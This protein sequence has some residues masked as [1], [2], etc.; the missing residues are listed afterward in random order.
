[1]PKETITLDEVL[2]RF[3]EAARPKVRVIFES[4]KFNFLITRPNE[5]K[6]GSFRAGMPGRN[7]VIFINRNLSKYGFLLIFLHEYAHFVVWKRQYKNAAP[8]GIEWKNCYR[9]ILYSFENENLFPDILRPHIRELIRTA[10][11]SFAKNMSL[12]DALLKLEGKAAPQRLSSLSAGA[13]FQLNGRQFVVVDKL[14]TRY[15]CR[16]ADDGR[17]YLISGNASIVQP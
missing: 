17:L 9:E 1:M 15:R 10:P 6:Y 11:A 13:P 4:E 3:P 14:R 2:L 5:S 12:F 16:C 8:H 7:P